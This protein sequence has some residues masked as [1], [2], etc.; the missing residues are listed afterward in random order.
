MPR[1]KKTAVTQNEEALQGR[2]LE[3]PDG[4]YWE[5]KATKGPRGPFDRQGR[6]A[7]GIGTGVVD[8][9]D[10]A[11]GPAVQD[12]WMWLAGDR[13][14][15][16]AQL[17]AVIEGYREFYEFDRAQ[18]WLIDQQTVHLAGERPSGAVELGQ[19]ERRAGERGEH[20]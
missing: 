16:Q 9:D 10:A 5:S 15:M 8:L 11:Q 12:L 1:R 3:R 4:F 6:R 19:L 20:L 2:V 7:H 18:L 17:A 13:A 14:S